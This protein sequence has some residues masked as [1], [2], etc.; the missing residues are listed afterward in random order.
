MPEQGMTSLSPAD[1]DRLK[2][3][4][5]RCR[6]M[7]GTLN[8]QLPGDS[9]A[10]RAERGADGELHLAS[11][12]AATNWLSVARTPPRPPPGASRAHARRA[13]LNAGDRALILEDGYGV[14]VE[15]REAGD[16]NERE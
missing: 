14:F 1:A 6:E 5:Q 9:S 3:A 4:F 11:L 2:L 10:P 7:D 13:D 8:E 15:T 16:R 12:S